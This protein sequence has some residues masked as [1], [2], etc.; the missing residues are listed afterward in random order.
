MLVDLLESPEESKHISNVAPASARPRQL[1]FKNGQKWRQNAGNSCRTAVA[2]ST[3][4]ASAAEDTDLSEVPTLVDDPA[5]PTV[6]AE[7]LR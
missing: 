1:D 4:T 7:Q 5:N 6:S 3:S 2:W